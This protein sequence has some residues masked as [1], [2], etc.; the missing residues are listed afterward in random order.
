VSVAVHPD[1][2]DALRGVGATVIS[3]PS[4]SPGD[5]VVSCELGEIDGRIE[6]RL[7]ALAK[8]IAGASG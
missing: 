4:L 3:D 1:D 6:V 7:D 2:V 5:C 8:A